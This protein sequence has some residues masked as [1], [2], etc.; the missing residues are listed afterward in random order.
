MA[1]RFNDVESAKVLIIYG[2]DIKAKNYVILH[3]DK[4]VINCL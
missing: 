4:I 1:A 3:L 2:A